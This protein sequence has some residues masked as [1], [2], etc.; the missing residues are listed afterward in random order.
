MSTDRT[1]QPIW[2]MAQTTQLG[3]ID[4][5]IFNGG[6]SSTQNIQWVF[7]TGSRKKIEK[8]A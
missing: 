5:K 8:V 6:I 3:L 1:A 7:N 4:K 2:L